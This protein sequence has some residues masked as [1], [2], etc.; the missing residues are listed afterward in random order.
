MHGEQPDGQLRADF[1]A[2][3]TCG[4]CHA[5]ASLSRP[6]AAGSQHG[7]HEGLDVDCLDCH[8]PATTYGL[9]TGML[10]HQIRAPDPG[11]LVGR[12]DQPDA[13][14]QCHVERSRSWAASAMADLGLSGSTPGLP[15][16][17]EAWASRVMLD[18]LGGDPVQRALAT[19]ALRSDRATLPAPERARWLLAGLADEYPA[20]RFMAWRGLTAMLAE[21][22]MAPVLARYD[23]MGP[24]DER[25]EVEGV[26]RDAL[27]A[28]PLSADEHVDR[29]ERLAAQRDD[30]EIW[31]GE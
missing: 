8:M 5:P 30:Q 19:H 16:D 15:E 25:L 29:R 24:L 11:A 14:T 12:H 9:L 27:G 1:S 22:P 26:L 21:H 2:T 13:C 28:P 23:F 20:V 6:A 7:G 18:L 4:R 31:I 10:S 17:S 3:S